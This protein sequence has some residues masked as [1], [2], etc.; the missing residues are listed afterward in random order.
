[1]GPADLG[2]AAAAILVLAAVIEGC[3]RPGRLRWVILAAFATLLVN[4]LLSWR[5][6]D[7]LGAVSAGST[8]AFGLFFSVGL[9]AVATVAGASAR[10]VRIVFE[11]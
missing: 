11:D 8:A 4:L 5:A 6:E 1:M 9:F 3:R 7:P 2:L 10:L